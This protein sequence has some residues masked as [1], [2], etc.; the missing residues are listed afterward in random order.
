MLSK[1]MLQE[2]KFPGVE[3]L[4]SHMA[5]GFQIGGKVIPTGVF[6]EHKREAWLTMDEAIAGAPHHNQHVLS[7]CG[8]SGDAE[9]DMEIYASIRTGWRAP[10]Q[11]QS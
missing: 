3:A 6:P 7:T 8:P 9:L 2:A 1:E 4:I 5:H 11:L 10:L